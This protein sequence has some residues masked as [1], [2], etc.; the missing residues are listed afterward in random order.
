MLS[1]TPLPNFPHYRIFPLL[2]L[3]QKLEMRREKENWEL[4]REGD[5]EDVKR[6]SEGERETEDLPEIRSTF[7]LQFRIEG[8]RDAGR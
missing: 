8:P 7:I 6:E 4:E 2:F 5:R 3:F 1:G